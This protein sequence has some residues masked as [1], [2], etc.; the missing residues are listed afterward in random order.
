VD[1]LLY[2]DRRVVGAIEAKP[3]GTTLSGVEWQSSMYG[4]G[5]A[6]RPPKAPHQRR[7]EAAPSA[8]P[9]RASATPQAMPGASPHGVPP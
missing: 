7:P 6:G 9:E 8:E 5:A 4:D 1:Y 2:V 3:V